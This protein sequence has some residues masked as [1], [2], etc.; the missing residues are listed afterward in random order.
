MN[1]YEEQYK[2]ARNDTELKIQK[3]RLDD[4]EMEDSRLIN[5][6]LID[7]ERVKTNALRML[8]LKTRL[9]QL[10]RVGE[11]FPRKE[12]ELPSMQGA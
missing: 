5:G 3:V 6:G 11:L 1:I 8:D 10:D 12:I 2:V 9:K 4:Q 7:A